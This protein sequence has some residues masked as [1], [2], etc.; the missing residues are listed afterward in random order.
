MG[1]GYPH[2]SILLQHPIHHGPNECQRLAPRGEVSMVGGLFDFSPFSSL[3][4]FTFEP[5]PLFRSIFIH[6]NRPQIQFQKPG[7]QTPH[8]SQSF[9]GRLSFRF[10]FNFLGGIS[11]CRGALTSH[12]SLGFVPWNIQIPP[13]FE[14]SKCIQVL[15]FVP[16]VSCIHISTKAYRQYLQKRIAIC[17]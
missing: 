11:Q 8:H 2:L 9:L 14:C 12:A 10:F 3:A 16:N 6:S 15:I 7:N 1:R 4:N 13:M 5:S 17:S